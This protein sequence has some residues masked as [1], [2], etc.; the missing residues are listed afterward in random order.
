MDEECAQGCRVLLQL[1]ADRADVRV[2]LP[3]RKQLVAEVDQGEVDEHN[4][5]DRTLGVLV[6]GRRVLAVVVLAGHC[7]AIR[8]HQVQGRGHH[9][10]L[11]RN[12]G[13]DEHPDRLEHRLHLRPDR[14]GV[15]GLPG[16]NLFDLLHE[17][18]DAGGHYAGQEAARHTAL[19]VLVQLE[20]RLAVLAVVVLDDLVENSDREHKVREERDDE[21]LLVGERIILVSVQGCHLL[22]RRLVGVA[23]VRHRHRRVGLLRLLAVYDDDGLVRH[24]LLLRLLAANSVKNHRYLRDRHGGALHRLRLVDVVCVRLQA[25]TDTARGGS[26]LSDVAAGGLLDVG[27]GFALM[28]LVGLLGA[29]R[30]LG[31]LFRRRLLDDLA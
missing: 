16:F 25:T 20:Y 29:G 18:L 21:L 26:L 9:Q 17:P 1:V 10:V 7:A 31:G 12:H 14:P 8:A 4:I 24:L 13:T 6:A 2:P 27:A 30:C 5:P 11:R 15:L 28:L 22:I 23:G 19:V 3:L